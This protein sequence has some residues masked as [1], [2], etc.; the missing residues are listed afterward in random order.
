LTDPDGFR[1]YK[2]LAAIERLQRNH[3]D[4][5][6]DREPIDALLIAETTRYYQYLTL[7][8]NILNHAEDERGSLLERALTDK[9]ERSLDRVYRLLGLIHPWKDVAAARASLA[10]GESRSRAA[11]IEYLDNLLDGPLRKR[12]MPILEDM[13]IEEKIAHA[14]ALLKIRSHG[15]EGSLGRLVRDDDPVI[16]A[17]AI[18]TV[19]R[20]RL[21]SLAV[22]LEYVRAHSHHEDSFVVESSPRNF[23]LSLCIGRRA[24]QDR[25][26]RPA[27]PLRRRRGALRR[28]R[29]CRARDVPHRG[30]RVSRP[31]ERAAKNRRQCAGS[32][33][34]SRNAAGEP[35]AADR[36]D[37]GRNG[38]L[39][40][41]GRSVPD[42]GVG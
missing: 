21:W 35:A 20:R 13:P 32:A 14:N 4:L 34:V 25:Q 30:A 37:A 18:Q 41:Y 38:G 3:P 33:C 10:S 2:V 7:R 5:V 28:R 22:D 12:V 42:D 40:V 17:A 39:V 6:F 19:A 23:A 26:H 15:L 27:E 29:A 11:A 8:F 31:I 36:Q 1:R 9:L 16:S 24:V